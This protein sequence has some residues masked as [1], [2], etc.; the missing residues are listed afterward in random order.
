MFIQNVINKIKMNRI[1]KIYNY[2]VLLIRDHAKL[3]TG[4]P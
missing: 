3:G 2:I 1:P 4:V